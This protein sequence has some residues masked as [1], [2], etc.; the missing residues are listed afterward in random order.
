MRQVFH[1]SPISI[2]PS[3]F[4]SSIHQ[5][6]TSSTVLHMVLSPGLSLRRS[7]IRA[8]A[9]LYIISYYAIDKWTANRKKALRAK[10]ISVDEFRDVCKK[11]ERSEFLTGR[12]GNPFS[13]LTICVLLTPAFASNIRTVIAFC[14]L[15][16]FSNTVTLYFTTIDTSCLLLLIFP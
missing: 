11:I 4:L 14:S 6:Q 9:C 16:G 10:K 1:T 3:R 8:K 5:F 13:I 7:S 2:C 15:Y 12:D